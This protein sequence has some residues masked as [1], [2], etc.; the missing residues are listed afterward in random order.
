M[1]NYFKRLLRQHKKPINTAT[2]DRVL[3]LLKQGK[4]CKVPRGTC[5]FAHTPAELSI[6]ECKFGEECCLPLARCRFLH[7]DETNEECVARCGGLLAWVKVWDVAMRD[8]KESSQVKTISKKANVKV[9]SQVAQVSNQRSKHW[10][11]SSLRE[12]PNL[13]FSKLI[14]AYKV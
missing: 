10:L 6:R 1:T 3:S 9:S 12:P 5:Y 13:F 7:Q 4:T 14:F 8:T 2:I 11:G